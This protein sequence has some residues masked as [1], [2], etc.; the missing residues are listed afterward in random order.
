MKTTRDFGLD[1]LDPIAIAQPHAFCARLR[2]AAPI[3]RSD[4]LHGWVLTRYGDV[5]RVLRE[6]NAI[7]ACAARC[8]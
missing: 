3:V 4:Q 1:L 6:V 2:V 8:W 7:P 5:R